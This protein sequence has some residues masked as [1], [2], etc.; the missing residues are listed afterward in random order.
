MFKKK[1]MEQINDVAV[2]RTDTG[3]AKT[4]AQDT[5]QEAP[6]QAEVPKISEINLEA[7]KELSRAINEKYAYYLSG[8]E[9]MGMSEPLR[10]SLQVSLLLAIYDELRQIRALNEE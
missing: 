7:L 5:H 2:T 9:A 3:N 4:K 1:K 6:K 8:E 10:D